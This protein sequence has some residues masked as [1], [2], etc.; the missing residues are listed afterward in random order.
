MEINMFTK[1][2]SFLG[3]LLVFSAILC[4]QQVMVKG[5]PIALT[6]PGEYFMAPKWSPD[7]QQV[8]AAG[9]NY[10][11]L[12]IIEVPIGTTRQI[13]DAYSAGYGFAWSHDGSRIAAK[14]SHFDNMRRSHTLV[15]FNT[16]DASMEL[17]TA[18]RSMMSGVPVWSKDDSHLF[19][20]FADA[21]QSFGLDG[22][23]DVFMDGNLHYVKDGHLQRR[24]KVNST[25]FNET[26]L[27]QDQVQVY[28]YAV[29]PDGS[30]IAYSTAGQNLWITNSDGENR[31]SLGKGYR[32]AWS[33]NGEWITF[34]LSEDDGHSITAADIYAIRFDGTF[35]F[36]ITN[37]TESIEMNPQWSPDG[38]WIVYDTDRLGQLFIQ[39]MDWR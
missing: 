15:W 20:T 8:A 29:S 12:Y 35:R 18:P 28:T 21:F 36:N 6:M 24:V 17:L 37:T 4:A 10:T 25:A 7:G 34:E 19:L 27:F 33:P 16:S 13:S 22:R 2:G 31:R 30:R 26:S 38:N 9:P 3:L 23:A 1:V 5:E 14:I 32:P 39:Q 11:G